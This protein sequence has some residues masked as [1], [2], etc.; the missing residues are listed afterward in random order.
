MVPLVWV[1]RAPGVRGDHQIP[2][3]VS[4]TM[5][6]AGSGR[7]VAT[8][9]FVGVQELGEPPGGVLEHS[10]VAVVE[11]VRMPAAGEALKSASDLAR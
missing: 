3:T 2:G 4:A 6:S 8:Q 1:C 11:F 7:A 5:G 9:G 10:G